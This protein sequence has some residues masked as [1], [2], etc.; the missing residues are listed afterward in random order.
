MIN[1]K[2]FCFTFTLF[3]GLLY[4]ITM[5]IIQIDNKSVVVHPFSTACQIFGH[6]KHPNFAVA[7][8]ID[9]SPF[10]FRTYKVTN[11]NCDR[12]VV[13]GKWSIKY[14][15]L[16]GDHIHLGI[17]IRENGEDLTLRDRKL[18]EPIPYEDYTPSDTCI[19]PPKYAYTKQWYH[20]GVH[21]HCDNI[22]HVHPWSAPR[23]LRVEG[24]SVVLGT[25]FE[26]VGISVRPEDNT[27]RMPNSTYRQWTLEYYVYV[28]DTYPVLTTTSVEEMVNLWL[29]D[30]HGFIKLYDSTSINPPKDMKVLE[31][32]SV[33]KFYGKYPKRRI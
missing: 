8:R 15:P 29:V 3:F 6:T 26:S 23:E 10:T 11:K 25:W 1:S 20:S 18:V 19:H 2:Q 4:Y 12:M 30:H 32:K 5:I 16:S 22:I 14:R 17:A 27:L 21:T 24:K 28:K 33:S 31:Y 9:E 13:Y 7:A